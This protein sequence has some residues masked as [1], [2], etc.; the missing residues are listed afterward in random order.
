M[1]KEQFPNQEI[2]NYQENFL[3]LERA[4]EKAVDTGIFEYDFVRDL[5]FEFVADIRKE[6]ENIRGY[7][8]KP[9]N[10][11]ETFPEKER[12]KR[13]LIKELYFRLPSKLYLEKIH[14]LTAQNFEED[15]FKKIWYEDID[16]KNLYS[17][18][19]VAVHE[20]AHI[21]SFNLISPSNKETKEGIKK[22][23]YFNSEYFSKQIGELIKEDALLK[24][25]QNVDFKK[26][27]LD[28]LAWSEIY[29][30]L[31]QR[32]FL[33]RENPENEKKIQKWDNYI[34]KVANNLAEI[35]EKFNQR[36]NRDIPL[37]LTYNQHVLSYLLAVPL[38]SKFK[39]FNESIKWLESFKND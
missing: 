30:L 38:E 12:E 25:L 29:A 31:Y 4:K 19:G 6:G 36:E 32:E 24:N 8:L 13:D 17:F 33:R 2:Q 14:N 15:T 26:F 35:V 10:R 7:Q 11:I 28:L 27:K 9:D 5:N 20:M 23:E 22:S 3:L 18:F 1:S 39:N 37:G 21:K 16:M 34:F